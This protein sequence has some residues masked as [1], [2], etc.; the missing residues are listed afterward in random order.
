MVVDRTGEK[1][2]IKGSVKILG[3][4]DEEGRGNFAGLF[5]G[6][7]SAAGGVSGRTV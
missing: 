7:L 4:V 1:Q 6:V 2:S 5:R 3:N